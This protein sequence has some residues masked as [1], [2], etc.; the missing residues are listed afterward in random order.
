M[1]EEEGWTAKQLAAQE[2][3]RINEEKARKANESKGGNDD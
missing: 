2:Q 3:E 1:S